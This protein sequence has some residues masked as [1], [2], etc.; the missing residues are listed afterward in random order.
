MHIPLLDYSSI[1]KYILTQG[2][3]NC[4][5]SNEKQCSQYFHLLP[6]TPHCLLAV[7]RVKTSSYTGPHHI[8]HT[9]QIFLHSYQAGIKWVFI[10]W[11]RGKSFNEFWFHIESNWN[12]INNIQLFAIYSNNKQKHSTITMRMICM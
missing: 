5:S 12:N 4:V 8:T 3:S 7:Q 2:K 6:L 9:G 1:I 11:M 10:P